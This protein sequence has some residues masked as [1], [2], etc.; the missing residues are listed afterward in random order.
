MREQDVF[1]SFIDDSETL[2][3]PPSGAHQRSWLVL[4]VDDDRDVH[5]TTEFALSGVLIKDRPLTFLHAYSGAEALDLLRRES[6]IAV[7]LLDVVMETDDAGLRIIHAIREELGLV[8]TRII[9]RTGQPGYAPEIETIS[10]YDINDYKT[11]NELVRHKLYTTLTT[12]IRCYDQLCQLDA[13]RRGLAQIIAASN[14]FILEQGLQTF[15][16]G[17]IIQIAAFAGIEPDGLVCVSAHSAT[18]TDELTNESTPVDSHPVITAATGRYRHLIQHRLEEIDDPRIIDHLSRCL[19][20]RHNLLDE[21]SLTLFFSGHDGYD[22]AAFVDSSQPLRE[23]DQHLLEVFCVNIALCADNVALVS[24]LRNYAFVDSLVNLPNRNAFISSIDQRLQE[25][26]SQKS[27]IALV[28]VDQFAEI[29]DLL[30]HHYGDQLLCAI[31]RRLAQEKFNHCLIARISGDQFG[32]FGDARR[33]RPE[34]LQSA[35][36]TP[37]DINGAEHRLSV[38]MG[39]AR[40]DPASQRGDEL[41]K[42]AS[43]ALKHAKSGG[44]GQ[45]AYYS[46]QVRVETRERTRLLHDLRRAFDHEHLFLVYQPQL[47]LQDRTVVGVEALLR[48]RTESGCFIPPDQFIPVAEQSG[49]IV[50]I[51]YW[52]LRVALHDAVR[53]RNAGYR[54]IRMA[55]NVSAVQ[56]RQ[57][58]F[59][60]MVEEALRDT[61]AGPDDLE[62]E[63]TESVAALG[64][65]YVGNVL[66]QLKNWGIRVAIDDFGTGFSSLSY[67]DRLPADRLKI[68]RSFV[69]ALDSQQPGARIAEIVITLGR[70][71]GMNVLA[72]G[73]ETALQADMLSQLA[74]NDA[75]GYYFGKP[76]P[77]EDL[78]HWLHA[79]PGVSS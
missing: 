37:F 24:R 8:N 12:A 14:Q 7:I 77:L 40:V 5:E 50:G 72:E 16:E 76:M 79:R 49:L 74:C 46:D 57:P 32:V 4:I 65:D 60:D 9:L 61:G 53:L 59:L 51:G 75:Q 6:T 56:F 13:S 43:I 20:E 26:A 48:W 70:K 62:L 73:V 21:R 25:D 78:L 31:A 58:T 67:L 66:R 17:V 29:N 3:H 18:P 38:S 28:D 55:V 45:V 15:A 71:L 22:L 69:S 10:R 64:F 41:L 52:L 33:V 36:T 19:Q 11:K 39:F 2:S 54:G 34:M 63:I 68:D 44:F 27:V 1:L 23:V 35:F 30:G 47:S 42:D